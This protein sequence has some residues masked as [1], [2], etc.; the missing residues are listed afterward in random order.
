[1]I[2]MSAFHHLREDA[3]GLGVSAWFEKPFD[4]DRLLETV[5]RLTGLHLGPLKA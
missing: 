4:L 1:V 2:V 5:E 3:P